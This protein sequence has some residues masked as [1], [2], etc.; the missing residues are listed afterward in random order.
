[1]CNPWSHRDPVGLLLCGCNRNAGGSR[2]STVVLYSVKQI[3]TPI[4]VPAFENL[5]MAKAGQYVVSALSVFA[6][7]ELMQWQITLV[8]RE[9]ET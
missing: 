7:K 3:G 5:S 6:I 8:V 9:L 2:E 4:C 1:M